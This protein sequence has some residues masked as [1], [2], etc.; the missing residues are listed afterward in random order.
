M[1][2]KKFR[3]HIANTVKSKT[4]TRESFTDSKSPFRRTTHIHR[5]R[6]ILVDT[7]RLETLVNKLFQKKFWEK[8]I[9][10]TI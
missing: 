10:E 8:T 4:K 2:W 7:W 5:Y 1:N 3:N 6:V 9:T